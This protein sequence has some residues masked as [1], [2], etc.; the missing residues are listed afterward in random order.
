MNQPVQLPSNSAPARIGQGTAVEQSRAIAEVQAAIVVAQQCPRDV[1]AA[2]AAMRTACEQKALAD[3]AF[4]RYSRGGSNVSGPTVH[5]AREIALAWGNIQYGLVEMR[6]DDEFGQSEMQAFA[7]DV[8]RNARNSSTFIVP[9]KRDVKG[10]PKALV[11]LRDIYENNANNGA[12]RVR[13]AIFAVLPL[14]YVEQAKDICN[15]TLAKGGGVPLPTRIAD[16]IKAFDGLGINVDRIESKLGRPQ[17]KWTDH[18]LA[19]LQV[20][21]QSIQRGEVSRDE[22]F[23]PERVTAAD[24]VGNKAK[25]VTDDTWTADGAQDWPAV[26]EVPTP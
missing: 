26:A 8:E 13:E 23:P 9:H 16:A 7:W 15:N 22:E 6:R 4:F 20:I 25:P 2:V 11:D 10:G 12:R 14:W 24:L 18:D 17:G 5:L 21:Y 1:P 19:Q 3:R